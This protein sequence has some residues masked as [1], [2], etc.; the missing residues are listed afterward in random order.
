MELAFAQ[1]VCAFALVLTVV[2]IL[3]LAVHRIWSPSHLLPIYLS[4]R[5]FAAHLFAC[6]FMELRKATVWLELLTWTL[7]LH[8]LYF[9]LCEKGA[10]HVTRILHGPSF[11]GAHAMLLTYLFEQ[12]AAPRQADA[13]I[14]S[15]WST[16]WQFW[17]HCAP[18]LLHWADGM[19][20]FQELQAAYSPPMTGGTTS[21]WDAGG[22]V[23]AMRFASTRSLLRAWS[24]AA[25]YFML[26]CAW[27]ATTK[28]SRRE[29]GVHKLLEV[30]S[31]EEVLRLA[32]S[33]VAY[34]VFT[35]RLFT[36]PAAP[37]MSKQQK[38]T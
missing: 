23:P 18:V 26:E 37:A 3:L 12:L 32:A 30:S 10:R 1:W 4:R 11:G 14:D 38:N 8:V 9:G 29:F 34:S 16:V 36:V 15:F 19:L 6:L 22:L 35:H 25:G 2:A 20:N 28:T 31:M 7:A 13:G 17:L 27:S 5:L 21:I 24:A 33:L